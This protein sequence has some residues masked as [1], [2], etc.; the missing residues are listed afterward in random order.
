MTPAALTALLAPYQAKSVSL[1][2][3]KRVVYIDRALA[4]YSN[5]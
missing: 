2:V 5:R 4:P 1:M 3:Y